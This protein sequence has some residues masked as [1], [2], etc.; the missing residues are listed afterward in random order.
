MFVADIE[1]P[2]S[3]TAMTFNVHLLLHLAR[4]MYNWGPLTSHSN[5]GFKHGK[6]QLLQII[7]AANGVHHQV[8]RHIC[9][10]F[11]LLAIKR[12]VYPTCS[13]KIR[14]YYD[15]LGNTKVQKT[16]KLFKSRYFRIRSK[17]DSQ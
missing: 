4:N 7:H 14:N 16:F 8:T 6:R 1:K 2:Y 3:A 11:R 13:I 15:Q 9:L 5:Y 17:V 10:D 12:A